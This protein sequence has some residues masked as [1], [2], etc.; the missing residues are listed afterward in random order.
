MDFSDN[1]TF[2][3]LIGMWAYSRQPAV[4]VAFRYLQNAPPY[5]E[6]QLRLSALDAL[7]QLMPDGKKF[8]DDWAERRPHLPLVEVLGTPD[9]LKTFKSIIQDIIDNLRSD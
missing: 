3:P 8:T 6:R 1:T 4:D 9:A 2:R 5:D 7:N